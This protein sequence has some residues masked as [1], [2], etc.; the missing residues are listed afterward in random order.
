MKIFE[1]SMIISEAAPGSYNQIKGRNLTGYF[2]ENELHRIDVMGNGQTV[3][4]ATEEEGEEKKVVGVNRADCSDVV[5]YVE[6]SDIKRI[7][8]INKPSGG[9]HPLSLSKET[10]RILDGFFWETA[11]RPTSRESIFDWIL[12]T[13]DQSAAD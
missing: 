7:A 9:L 10:D 12:P 11:N 8:M 3:Y 13:P 5:I 4:Y 6:D 2:K 1:A